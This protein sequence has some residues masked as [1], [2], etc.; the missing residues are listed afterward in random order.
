MR[1]NKEEAMKIYMPIRM[2]CISIDEIW[3]PD[4]HDIDYGLFLIF[5]L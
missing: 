1:R 4:R 5:E 2:C 3:I